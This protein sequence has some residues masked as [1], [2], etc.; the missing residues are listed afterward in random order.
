[1]KLTVTQTVIYETVFVF[2]VKDGVVHV[3]TALPGLPVEMS[4]DGGVT[5][6][7]C[8]TRCIAPKD[9]LERMVLASRQVLYDSFKSLQLPL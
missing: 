9:S 7:E 2:S 4:P 1:M 5:W 6:K 3:N 8:T